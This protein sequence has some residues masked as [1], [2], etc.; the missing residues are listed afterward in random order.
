MIGGTISGSRNSSISSRLPTKSRRASVYAAGTPMS[1][2]RNTTA[3]TTSTVTISTEPS[4]NSFH[5]AVYHVVVQPSGSHVPSQ[6][7]ANELV[8]TAAIMSPMLIDEQRHRAQQQAAPDAVE[9]R[10]RSPVLR[11]QPLPPLTGPR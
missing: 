3:N 1:S 5:A 8:T 6:R 10:A 2:A 9:P 4:W 7:R 11:S